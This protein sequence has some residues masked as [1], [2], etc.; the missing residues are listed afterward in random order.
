MAMF[1]IPRPCRRGFT[2]FELLVVL[3]LLVVLLGLA[4]P[5]VQKVR[6]A[7]ARIHCANNLHQI[8]LATHICESTYGKLPPAIGPFP[9]KDGDGTV[10]FY[11]LPF[12]EQDNV[13]KN[14]ADAAGVFSV[15]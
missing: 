1:A 14:A 8:T 2:L 9:A 6:E 11:L 10:H 13:Y 7:A 4:L 15:W 5:V 12:I 3:A